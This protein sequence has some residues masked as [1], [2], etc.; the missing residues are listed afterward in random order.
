VKNGKRPTLKQ[1]RAI[2]AAKL[3]P[4]EWLVYKTEPG[5]LHI[6]NRFTERTKVIGL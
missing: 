3:L 5:R 6:I 2:M 4:S 1:K